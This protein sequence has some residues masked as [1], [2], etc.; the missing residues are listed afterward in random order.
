M[1]LERSLE[2]ATGTVGGRV[3]ESP[4]RTGGRRSMGVPS[5]ERVFGIRGSAL[6]TCQGSADGGR[7]GGSNGSED[8]VERWELFRSRSLTGRDAV[9]EFALL[10]TAPST[11]R[12][13]P[14]RL[15]ITNISLN[16]RSAS[17]ISLVAP[18]GGSTM[19][20]ARPED[21]VISAIG[22]AGSVGASLMRLSIS[23]TL[24]AARLEAFCSSSN[25]SAS[26]SSASTKSSK[27]HNKSSS[28]D[29]NCPISS[30]FVHFS[31]CFDGR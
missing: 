9:R 18:D 24:G 23:T 17:A 5:S 4:P 8:I 22:D 13:G 7:G 20:L 26:N 11:P 31:F 2:G 14:A 12:S 3:G 21:T 16:C 1:L 25:L 30:V 19:T 29:R 6:S 28:S 10:L 27:S 15:P